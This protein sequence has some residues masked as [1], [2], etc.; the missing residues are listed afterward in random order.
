[1]RQ[2]TCFIIC[3]WVVAQALFCASAVC[4]ADTVGT[5]SPPVLYTLNSNAS[6][7]IETV[8]NA[9]NLTVVSNNPVVLKA[10]YEA[11]FVQGHLQA[12]SIPNARDNI[13]PSY[14]NGNVPP[15]SSD[16]NK[17]N[18]LLNQ[19]YSFFINYLSTSTETQA[20]ANLKRLLFRMLGIYHG[21]TRSQPVALDFSGKWLP[22]LNYFSTA[23]MNVGYRTP[24]TFA[25]VYF[26]NSAND[27]GDVLPPSWGPNRGKKNQTHCSS[28]MKR[29]AGDI[30][31]AHNSWFSFE[32]MSMTMT[33]NVN[34][35]MFTLNA[36]T[37]GQIGSVTDFGY[38]K[39][40]IMFN[41]TTDWYGY[42]QPVG[43]G[44]WVFW[45]A[46][47]AEEFATSIDDFYHYMTLD[48]TGTYQSSWQVADI[49][50]G[51]MAVIDSSYR[52]F[53]FARSNGGNYT[54][55]SKPSGANLSYDTEM[56]TPNYLLGYNH[57]PFPQ[58]RND[59]DD[60]TPGTP[61][62][63]LQMKTLIPQVVDIASGKSV[64][65]YNTDDQ[66]WDSIFGRFDLVTPTNPTPDFFGAIDAKVVTGSM[67]RS[68]MNLQGVLD[69]NWNNPA[70]WMRYGTPS[71]NG[72]PF[73]WSQ[74]PW[75]NMPH[76]GVPDV[77]DGAWNRVNL[78]MY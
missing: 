11:G 68:F 64:I 57:S 76:F 56:L 75:P 73:I 51:E 10:E 14:Y 28:F 23:E 54:V 25:D 74:S 47:L 39:H 9:V 36:W 1:M 78:H 50:T 5:N 52:Y 70:Y 63:A 17:V 42:T 13:W 66:P 60:L 59:S 32:D 22:D 29:V 8:N 43:Q 45:R 48:N 19:N 4:F 24:L 30:V 7:V 6:G 27:L 31:M 44:L 71:V 62:R 65:T 18:Q 67:V 3:R 2:P 41:E 34:G 38:N 15:T 49:K 40:G 72:K 21:A 55:T 61:N 33:F 20:V 69:I 35:N 12:S 77:V 37:P 26:V 53:L 46:A 58:I 16:I